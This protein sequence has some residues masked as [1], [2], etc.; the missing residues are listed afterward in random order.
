MIMES[1]DSG[2]QTRE[3]TRWL[4]GSRGK[5]RGLPRGH[6]GVA[7]T[8]TEARIRMCSPACVVTGEPVVAA[9]QTRHAGERL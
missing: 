8:V 7:S 1:V 4:Y 6:A 5:F 2:D 3:V 9:G